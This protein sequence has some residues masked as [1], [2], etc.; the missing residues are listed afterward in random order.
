MTTFFLLAN[1]SIPNQQQQDC[2]LIVEV[3]TL[4]D[5]DNVALQKKAED[6]IRKEFDSSLS[7]NPISRAAAV[8]YLQTDEG[9]TTG[10]IDISSGILS[11]HLPRIVAR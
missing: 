9:S 10:S 6:E 1:E 7:F 3:S 8:E 5:E 2:R 11:W 4:L